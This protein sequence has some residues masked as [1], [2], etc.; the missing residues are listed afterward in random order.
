MTNP[1]RSSPVPAPHAASAGAPDSILVDGKLPPFKFNLGAVKPVVYKGGT[2]KQVTAVD[3]PVSRSIAGVYMTLEPGGLRELHWHANA[4]EW[5]YVFEGNLRTTVHDPEGR[6]EINDFGPGDLWYFPRGHGHSI[7]GIGPGTAKFLLAFDNGYFS[8]FATF[9][10]TDWIARTP[11]DIVAKNLG[12]PVA[13]IDD[14]PT[15]AGGVYISSGPVPPPLDRTQALGGP[16][17]VTPLSHKFSLRAQRPYVSEPGGQIWLASEKQFPLSTTMTGAF[18]AL[19]PGGLRELHW[20][21]NADEW[22]YVNKGKLRL[23][24]FASSGMAS[25]VE[26]GPGDVGFVPMGFGHALESIGDE[27][28]EAV[29]VFNSGEYQEI[30]LS[31]W[32]ASNPSYLL[33]NNFVS[34]PDP[35]IAALPRSKRFFVP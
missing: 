31:A 12:L 32:L 33:Q 19:P 14:F 8:E 3:F 15:K 20:H 23:T 30:G 13:Q 1:S 27:P 10:V 16:Q 6:S 34:V 24:V 18:L 28:A 2:A 17:P 22:Q 25:V 11:K 7:Q 9:S 21:P 4:A 29:L 35:V 5:A 26:L